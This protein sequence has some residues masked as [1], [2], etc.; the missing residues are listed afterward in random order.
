MEKG[1]EKV[2]EL[3]QEIGP[4]YHFSTFQNIYYERVPYRNSKFK[5]CTRFISLADLTDQKKPKVRNA[6]A[7]HFVVFNFKIHFSVCTPS[8]YSL[9]TT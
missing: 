3:V 7:F 5:H 1:T 6:C 9:W 4:R 2:T 8:T